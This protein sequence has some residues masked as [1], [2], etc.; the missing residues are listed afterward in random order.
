MGAG[1]LR[2][3]LARAAIRVGRVEHC[4]NATAMCAMC[5]GGT[6]GTGGAGGAV[7]TGTWI[8]G[9]GVTWGC[10]VVVDIGCTVDF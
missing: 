10:T 4:R 8:T 3:L 2:A 7:I 6:T 1:G 5:V 9:S